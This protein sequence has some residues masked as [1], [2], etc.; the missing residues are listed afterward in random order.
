M[1]EY[2]R[3]LPAAAVALLAIWVHWRVSRE[4]LGVTGP[5]L[6][7][8]LRPAVSTGLPIVGLLVATGV[9]LNAISHFGVVRNDGWRGWF[10]GGCIA[11][12][13]MTTGAYAIWRLWQPV[14]RIDPSRRQFLLSAGGAVAA[15]PLGVTAYGI[16]IG[17]SD[18]RVREVDLPV[19]GLPRDLQCLRIVQLTDIHLSPFL[20]EK[21]LEKV[22]GMAN[23]LRPHLTVVTGDLITSARDPLDACLQR[24]SVL[25]ADAGVFGCL[26]NHEIYAAAEDYAAANGARLG[27]RF[28]R[29]QAQLLRFG[30]ADLNLVGVDYQRM[31]LPYLPGAERWVRR[32]AL[33]VLL[34]HNPDVFPIAAT[35]GYEVTLAG[36]THGGQV[37]IEILEQHLSVARFFTPYTSGSYREGAAALY[38]SRGIGTVGVPARVGAPPEVTLLRL[39]AT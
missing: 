34:S 35:K 28:L 13:I 25:R 14:A 31:R 36:H 30:G 16:L 32:G 23:D 7:P 2:V 26:G 15:A 4:V 18:F 8:R 19:P 1:P 11:W 39:C 33:N 24:L 22:V 12:A 38:V 29:Q 5:R 37:T 20:S 3:H 6:S 21:D 27:L 10:T 9:C 17:R